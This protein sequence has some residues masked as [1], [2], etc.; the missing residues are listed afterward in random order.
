MQIE[1][2]IKTIQGLSDNTRRA[3]EQTLWQLDSFI[4]TDEPTANDIQKFLNTFNAS[5]LHRHKAG[6]KAYWE[7]RFK[8]T[9]WPFNRR[10]FMAPRQILPRYVNPEVV[11][12]MVDL[13]E[14]PDDAMFIRTLFMMGCR[15]FELRAFENDLVTDNGVAVKT[16][17]GA[18]KLKV[19]TKDFRDVFLR[20]AKHKRGRIFPMSYNYYYTLLKRL[21]KEVGQP[22]LAPHMLRHARAIDLLRKGMQLSDV[23][24]FLGHANINTTARYLLITG[25][26]LAEQLEKVEGNHKTKKSVLDEIREL[27]KSDPSARATLRQILSDEGE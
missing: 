15:I 20:Y 23:Q 10:S 5:T 22:K 19:F 14:N 12:Q 26:D 7:Y 3:Y 27:V 16:K 9:E 1:Q 11:Y 13:A 18:T 17:G 6:V 21:G 4:K 2:F 25:G 24:Q 8:G